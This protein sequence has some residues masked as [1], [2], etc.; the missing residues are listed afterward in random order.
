MFIYFI[1]HACRTQNVT[2]LKLLQVNRH[3]HPMIHKT[4]GWK[5]KINIKQQILLNKMELFSVETF[6]IFINK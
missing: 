2:I 1:L 5:K 3:Y 6:R 4:T